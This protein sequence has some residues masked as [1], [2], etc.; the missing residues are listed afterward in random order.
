MLNDSEWQSR[1]SAAVM[2]G[3]KV[4]K[5]RSITSALALVCFLLAFTTVSCQRTARGIIGEY[6]G[7]SDQTLSLRI[8]GDIMQV[9]TG[10][11]TLTF[12]Y[13]IEK[14]EGNKIT[15]LL[16][17]SVGHKEPA[18]LT[19]EGNQLTITGHGGVAGHWK[20]K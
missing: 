12:K 1:R 19:L 14:V 18:I 5:R 4:K 3:V 17:D 6:T 15:A 16:D 2:H 7:E 11:L 20:R 13:S 8:T 10:P 9:N